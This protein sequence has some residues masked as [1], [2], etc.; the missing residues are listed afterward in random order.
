MTLT[1]VLATLAIAG[2]PLVLVRLWRST[3]KVVYQGKGIPNTLGLEDLGQ[4]TKTRY[5]W[6]YTDDGAQHLAEI[7]IDRHAQIKAKADPAT[8]TVVRYLF[9][10]TEVETITWANETT[11]EPSVSGETGPFL[12]A[13][14][15]FMGGLGAMALGMKLHDSSD[16][17]VAMGASALLLAL[18]GFALNLTTGPQPKLGELSGSML[19]I[20]L[21]KGMVSLVVMFAISLAI[22]IACFSS[23]SLFAFF[24]GIHAAFALGGVTAIGLKVRHST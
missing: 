17:L 1:I 8:I 10:R 12:L 5:C 16:G 24:P 11:A 13:L 21:G 6:F 9:G 19:G 18:A 23:V 20:P 14:A 15:Y 2:I 4:R 7:S 3:R 22:T